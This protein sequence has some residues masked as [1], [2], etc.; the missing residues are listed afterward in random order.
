M[1]CNLPQRGKSEKSC[2]F[3]RIKPGL[4]IND[5]GKKIYLVKR[6]DMTDRDLRNFSLARYLYLM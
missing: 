5:L 6:K 4:I 1:V 2:K 3:F